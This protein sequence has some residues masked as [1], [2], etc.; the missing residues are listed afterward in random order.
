MTTASNE[1]KRCEE[2]GY[3][4]S[5][6]PDYKALNKEISDLQKQ[7]KGHGR[8]GFAVRAPESRYRRL[9]PKSLSGKEH[10]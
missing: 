10:R 6:S 5:D 3:I 4:S 9:A 1:L 2:L 7:L 8:H